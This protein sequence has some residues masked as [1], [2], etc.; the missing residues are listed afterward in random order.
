MTGVHVLI[1]S[2]R[3]SS[4][5]SMLMSA[6][7]TNL[8]LHLIVPIPPNWTKLPR[9]IASIRGRS[10]VEEELMQGSPP[11]WVPPWSEIPLSKHDCFFNL[12][13][14]YAVNLT[15][16]KHVDSF[17][18]LDD[19]VSIVYDDSLS[20]FLKSTQS[21][22]I[23]ADCTGWTSQGASRSQSVLNA[24]TIQDWR[25]W[26]RFLALWP[27]DPKAVLV[28]SWWN[29][30]F[31]LVNRRSWSDAGLSFR[32]ER[33]VALYRNLQMPI[34]SLEYGLV[35]A[36]VAFAGHVNCMPTSLINSGLGFS[37]L[38]KSY[39]KENVAPLRHYNGDRKP[40]ADPA[41]RRM[42]E[43]EYDACHKN[44]DQCGGR[45]YRGIRCCAQ[46]WRCKVLNAWY[47]QCVPFESGPCA[48]NSFWSQCGGRGFRGL[49]CC[50]SGARCVRY[51]PYYSQCVPL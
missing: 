31:T 36:Q 7:M 46:G 30:G 47:A 39:D 16:L 38:A 43:D 41:Y 17:F 5:I 23:V 26:L 34:A 37:E 49:S 50:T 1:A 48:T 42:Q 2:D 13:R 10:Q 4:S 15:Q 32:Y 3:L 6:C 35:L 27:Y 12:V 51:N 44:W 19:D 14:F 18:L 24:S 9:C 29:F 28:Q 33:A 21:A 45:G 40:R 8:S 22:A 25:V 20:R 11:G